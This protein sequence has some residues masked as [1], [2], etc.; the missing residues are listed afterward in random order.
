M[1]TVLRQHFS[2]LLIEIALSR[3]LLNRI[4]MRCQADRYALHKHAWIS[5]LC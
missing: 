4:A 5:I 2:L 1:S 3:T